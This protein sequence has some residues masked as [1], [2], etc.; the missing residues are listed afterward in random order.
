MRP[1]HWIAATVIA[2]AMLGCMDTGIRGRVP[3]GEDS[4]APK[5][6]EDICASKHEES[7][8]PKCS[9]VARDGSF[10]LPL[11]AGTYWLCTRGGWKGVR[12]PSLCP[13]SVSTGEVIEVGPDD[14]RTPMPDGQG[15][16]GTST[17]SFG[18]PGYLDVPH[19][20][21]ICVGPP[22][23]SF[24]TPTAELTC[25]ETD[26]CGRYVL[27]VP[28][29][30]YRVLFAEIDERETYDR[31][32]CLYRVGAGHSFSI[33]RVTGRGASRTPA[34]CEQGSSPDPITDAELI[35]PLREYVERDPEQLPWIILEE[36]INLTGRRLAAGA[37]VEQIADELQVEVEWLLEIVA[38][39]FQS[40]PELRK[41]IPPFV[42][43][44]EQR[45]AYPRSSEWY[46]DDDDRVILRGSN[47]DEQQGTVTLRAADSEHSVEIPRERVSW[48]TYELAFPLP[49]GLPAGRHV[50]SIARPD[51]LAS[52]P[53]DAV[54]VVPGEPA[55]EPAPTPAPEPA[56]GAVEGPEHLT[57]TEIKTGIEAVKP[58]AIACGPK[59]G[60]A[61]GLE[62]RV[63]FAIAGATGKVTRADPVPEHAGTPLG[64][65]VAE[66]ARAASFPTFKKDQMSFTF[67]FRM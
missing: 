53:R 7:E 45:V 36:L 48:T 2:L 67:T 39:G 50:V 38:G 1:N 57:A 32:R 40:Q 31:Q 16:Y 33:D 63:R 21:R 4:W 59:H 23:A 62:V 46:P 18:E 64:D 22:D 30:S 56:P 8:D 27:S 35:G 49:D 12:C 3:I 13:Y 47:F 66:A 54:I 44:D 17:G 58:A 25:V 34:A 15:F 55:P 10:E 14:F 29:G 19:R 24:R 26:R 9:K 28:E 61:S 20:M 41:K 6:G 37:S 5:P 43:T 65:C 11:P 60:A 51:G 52:Y 42:Q